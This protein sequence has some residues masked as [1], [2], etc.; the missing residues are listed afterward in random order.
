MSSMLSMLLFTYPV[1]DGL[2]DLPK[3]KITN[4]FVEDGIGK[5]DFIVLKD[6][7]LYKD[8]T[9]TADFQ[10]L[11]KGVHKIIH[12]NDVSFAGNTNFIF[13]DDSGKFKLEKK[14]RIYINNLEI[15]NSIEIKLKK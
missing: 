1:P 13:N 12:E 3:E 5:F 2:F 10:F 14:S 6:D 9:F 4:R 11:T 8:E 7:K 15:V